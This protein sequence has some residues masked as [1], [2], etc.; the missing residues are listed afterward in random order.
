MTKPTAYPSFTLLHFIIDRK[1]T[2]NM[3]S[4][5]GMSQKGKTIKDQPGGNAKSRKTGKVFVSPSLWK[6]K[7]PHFAENQVNKKEEYKISYFLIIV[8]K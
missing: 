7:M 6:R 1:C 3:S 2:Y 5:L 4:S 8:V